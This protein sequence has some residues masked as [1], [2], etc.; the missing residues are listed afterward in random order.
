MALFFVSIVQLP[1]KPASRIIFSK[2][3][4]FLNKNLITYLELT[5][6]MAIVGSSAV[7]GKLLIASFPVFLGA[8]LRFAIASAILL[9]MLIRS[10]KGIPP[11]TRKYWL[12]IFLQ[13]LTEGFF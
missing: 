1:L 11:I 13:T 9:P 10:E 5:L 2:R 12:F 4:L 8:G 3:D 7:V 6:A